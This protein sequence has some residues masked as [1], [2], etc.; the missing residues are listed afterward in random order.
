MSTTLSFKDALA[1][2]KENP[3]GDFAKAMRQ[4]IESGEFDQVAFKQGVDLTPFGRPSIPE[5]M[6]TF[7]D[8]NMFDVAQEDKSRVQRFAEGASNIVGGRYLAE[9]LGKALASPFVRKKSEEAM[10]VAMEQQNQ[11]I[12]RLREARANGEDTTRLEQALKLNQQ[13]IADASRIQTDFAE[14]LPSN[15]Q[16]IGSATKLATTAVSGALAG[17]LAK[18]GTGTAG[19]LGT[20]KGATMV[21]GLDKVFKMGQGTNVLRG[22]LKG[23]GV[24]ATTGAIEGAGHGFGTALEQEKSGS[25]V[26][27]SVVQGTVLGGAGG[28][29]IGGVAGGIGAKVRGVQQAKAERASVFNAPQVTDDVALNAKQQIT[30]TNFTKA[31]DDAVAKGDIPADAVYADPVNKVLQPTVAQGKVDDIVGTLNQ[32]DDSGQLADSFAKSIDVNSTSFD[33][34]TRQANELIDETRK[35]SEFNA[36]TALYKPDGKGGIVKDKLARE[37][38]DQGVPERHIANLKSLSPEDKALVNKMID[39]SEK[40]TIDVGASKRGIDAVGEAVEKPLKD[41]VRINRDM[42]SK[43]DDVAKSLKGKPVQVDGVVRNFQDDLTN[44][45]VKI[46]PS[47]TF[48][49]EVD[50]D[51]VKKMVLDFKGSDFEGIPSAQKALNNVFDRVQTIGDDAYEAH[52]LKRFIDNTV[53]Y[54]KTSEGIVGQAEGMLKGLRSGVDGQLDTTYQLYNKANMDYASTRQA[55]DKVMELTG[56]KFNLNDPNSNVRLGMVARRMFGNNAK[57]ADIATALQGMQDAVNTFGSKPYKHDYYRLVGA[58]EMLEDIY[59]TQATTS[60]QGQVQRGVEGALDGAKG[61]AGMA[62]KLKNKGGIIDVALDASIEG[63]KRLKGINKENMVNSI[64]TL[65]Q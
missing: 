37:A 3:S 43:L 51:V 16:V 19:I 17:G 48:D 6:Q 32:I 23:A 53:Q 57:R 36:T 63:V 49:V 64:R 21:G 42:G 4:K 55:I 41:L 30:Q 9:G 35:A 24:G 39:Y 29:I 65:L 58:T 59:G 52:R 13:S 7:D 10:E 46:R 45:G 22:I 33:D 1:Q 28:G 20:T 8:Q 38:L 62:A 50:G 40:A 54:G 44:A 18:A 26:V 11:L 31:I 60:L 15:K 47:S 5:S 34:I 25:D 2:A 12:A 14:S 61:I 27:D 56:S